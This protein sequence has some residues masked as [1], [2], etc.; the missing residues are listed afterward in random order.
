M[1][2][3]RKAYQD[4]LEWKNLSNGTTA[5]F[6]EGA[7]RVGKS[8]IA[9]EFAKHEYE[10]YL[11]IDFATETERIRNLFREDIGNMD[12]FFRNLSIIKSKDLPRRKSVIILDEI[13]LFPQARQAIKYLVKDGRY[14]YIETGSLISI[15]R[16]K[17]K[18]LIPSEEYPI[19]MFPMDFEE[20]LWARGDKV[21]F[22]AIRQAYA[23]CE[24]LGDTLHREIMKRFKEYM[25]VGGMPQVI[26]IFVNGG[27]Y[28]QIDLQKLTILNLY[29][30]DLKQY[31]RDNNTR[32]SVI[33]S[34]IP[35]QLHNHNSH[36]KFS[37]I[38]KNARYRDYVD[39]VDFIGDSM[40]GN[41]CTGVSMPAVDLESYADKSQFKLYMG[42]TG[43]LLSKM[44]SFN[45]FDRDQLYSAI[46]F[47][48]IGI[49][50]GYIFENI[51]A[52]MLRAAGHNLYYHNFEYSPGESTT[53]TR[54]NKYEIDFLIVKNRHVCPV[55]VKSSSYKRHAS[56]DYFRKKYSNLKMSNRYII[57]TKDFR[58]EKDINYLP[59]YMT[60]L[61]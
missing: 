11:I 19:K 7:R 31:D 13:Q 17:E 52:Q 2:F 22:E 35:E 15:R 4:L 3:E 9:E 27:S 16:N 48:K 33:F 42:D 46:L 45:K 41:V 32:S 44:I 28:A 24:S 56:F 43:L 38:D 8:T 34:S 40:M 51:T 12:T 61:L 23:S 58:R 59:I 20:F 30:H 21:T 55:E 1:L 26:S 49:D 53:V 47:D 14:D 57:Y 10:D 36:F 60:G 37:L 25:V 18:I 50:Y 29:E 5:A 54:A 6:I 39:A